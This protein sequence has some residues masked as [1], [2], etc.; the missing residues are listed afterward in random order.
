MSSPREA[1]APTLTP[2]Q[3]ALVQQ[4]LPLA[5]RLGRVVAARY[6]GLVE[7]ADLEALGRA[8]L[9]KAAL[10]FDPARGTPFETFAWGFVRGEMMRSVRDEA[11]HKSLLRSARAAAHGWLEQQTLGGDLLR[12]TDDDHAKRL[13]AF[14]DGLVAAM[15]T[16]LVAAAETRAGEEATIAKHAY[17]AAMRALGAAM[18]ELNARDRKLLELHYWQGLELKQVATVLGAGYTTVRRQHKHAIERL[19]KLLRGRGVDAPPP[20]ER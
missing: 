13:E 3:R 1:G 10:S 20:S 7:P 6:R 5:E 12:D 4:G 14:S 2:A 17:G 8:G 19:G 16:G 11:E 9:V 18:G 15:V